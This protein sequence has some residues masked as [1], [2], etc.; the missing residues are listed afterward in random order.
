MKDVNSLTKKELAQI[1]HVMYRSQLEMR[2]AAHLKERQEAGEIKKWAY[3]KKQFRIA[4]GAIYTPDFQITMPHGS[5]EYHEV[6]GL[7][8]GFGEGRLK[9]MVAADKNPKYKWAWVTQ[10]NG[11]WRIDYYSQRRGAKC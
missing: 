7:G 8:N 11:R 9:W 5:V 1:A 3:E 4:N 2:Y 10:A 6:K